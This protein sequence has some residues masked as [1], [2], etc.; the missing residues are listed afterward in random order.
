MLRLASF[1]RQSASENELPGVS[2]DLDPQRGWY[3]LNTNICEFLESVPDHQKTR[4]HGED[5][6]TDPDRSLQQIAGWMG[7]RTDADAIEAMKHPEHSPYASPGPP[8]ARFGSDY[9]LLQ[10]PGF[11]SDRA[12]FQKLSG[13][14]SWRA[15]GHGFLPEVQRLAQEFGYE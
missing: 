11:D 8:G 14:L 7:L 10:H 6:V 4:I 3:V 2:P 9:F 13:P 5:L 1:P 15:D 12:D